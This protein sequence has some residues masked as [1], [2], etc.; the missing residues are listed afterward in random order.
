MSKNTSNDRPK[1]HG[2][3]K[4]YGDNEDEKMEWKYNRNLQEEIKKNVRVNQ[5]V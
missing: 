5:K 2:C 1:Q 4:M 3:N